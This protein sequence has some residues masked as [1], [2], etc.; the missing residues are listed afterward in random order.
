MVT[1]GVIRISTFVSLEIA[2][3]HSLAIIATNR[4]AN[5]P[6][7]PPNALEAKPTV[8][9]ENNTNGGHFNA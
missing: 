6:P 1:I 7:A 5:G 3:P 2:L 8:I 4:T 9:Y